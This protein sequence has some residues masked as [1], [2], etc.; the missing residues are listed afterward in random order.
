MKKLILL[1]A[2][3][4]FTFFAYAQSNYA[5]QIETDKKILN[6]DLLGLPESATILEALSI[7]PE[8]LT[9][10][11]EVILNNY[12]V[13]IDGFSLGVAYEGTLSQIRIGQVERIEISESPIDSYKNNG[14]GGSIDIILRPKH[15]GFSGEASL[16]T[17]SLF[18]I[19]PMA[20]L[21]YNKNGLTL[22]GIAEFEHY[23]P[24]N[25]VSF[26]QG[27]NDDRQ[28]PYTQA[29]TSDRKYWNETVRLMMEYH[30]SEKDEFKLRF[31][32]SYVWDDKDLISDIKRGDLFE[33][34]NKT[35]TGRRFS[36]DVNSS[37]KHTFSSGS[38]FLF[39]TTYSHSPNDENTVISGYQK[40]GSQDLNTS[41]AGKAE[42][43]HHIKTKNAQNF[44]NLVFGVNVNFSTN[45]KYDNLFFEFRPDEGNIINSVVH[46]WF[47]SP[48]AK[49]DAK[50]GKWRLKAEL[51]YQ[52]FNYIVRGIGNE[53]F[54]KKRG[55]ITGKIMAG[56]QFNPNNHIQL[57]LDRKLERPDGAM[58]YPFM[59][60]NPDE[61]R[62]EYGNADLIP[63]TVNEISLD[64]ITNITKGPHNIILNGKVS[65]MTVFDMLTPVQY[66]LLPEEKKYIT[67]ENKGENHI[68]SGEV[69]AVYR[70]GCMTL[71]FSGNIYNNHM[72][73][74]ESEDNYTYYN[75]SLF[76]TFHFKHDWEASAK[77]LYHSR[78]TTSETE[79]GSATTLTLYAGKSWKKLTVS[80]IGIIPLNGKSVDY[81]QEE[82]FMLKKTYFYV[83]PYAGITLNY[84]F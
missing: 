42:Y 25:V 24:L 3:L 50:L 61:N 54:T 59:T 76:P 29:D 73:D 70:V 69:S 20:L 68:V 11:E 55:D 47:I 41:I 56:W 65:Y 18:D 71:S 2:T 62:Y 12:D 6:M 78:V 21:A 64:Y 49:Y 15:E 52:D 46:T 36:L 26:S 35:Y 32:E 51:E 1:S 82:D 39:E 83:Y 38:N 22:R 84:K 23:H 57:I 53:R 75:L 80:A 81:T 72:V 79:I 13:K 5:I 66:K 19:K 43:G 74:D 14:Q 9:R 27:L 37:F 30:P 4:L 34:K 77:A 48:Y 44:T 28:F 31:S 58:L 8:L 10:N 63:M 40:V 45:E 7:L 33:I 60:Y 17:Y 16:A 67:Y